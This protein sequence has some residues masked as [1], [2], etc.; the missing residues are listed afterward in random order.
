MISLS[1]YPS[2]IL[3]TSTCNVEVPDWMTAEAGS[4]QNGLHYANRPHAAQKPTQ[5]Q[6]TI[7]TAAFI[8]FL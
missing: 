2:V 1:I 6:T 4:A 8:D 5:K 3:I 7:S